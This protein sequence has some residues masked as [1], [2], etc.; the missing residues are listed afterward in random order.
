MASGQLTAVRRLVGTR[1]TRL[2]T[3]L[4]KAYLLSPL[5]KYLSNY[6]FSVTPRT[7]PWA[8]DNDSRQD[9]GNPEPEPRGVS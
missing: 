3:Y 1:P 2:C 9:D 7:T 5:W 4:A 8:H 6:Q